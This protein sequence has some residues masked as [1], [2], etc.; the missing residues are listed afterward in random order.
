MTAKQAYDTDLAADSPDTYLGTGK[1]REGNR[2]VFYTL[3]TLGKRLF[4]VLS[5]FLIIRAII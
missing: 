2:I 4:Y 3:L 1:G 5:N